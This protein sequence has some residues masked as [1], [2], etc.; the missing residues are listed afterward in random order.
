MKASSPSGD[1][2]VL[3]KGASIERDFVILNARMGVWDSRIYLSISNLWR[4][5][6]IFICPSFLLLLKLSLRFLFGKNKDN[7]D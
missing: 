7:K 2:E 1:F 3:I 5:T 6:T 4:I